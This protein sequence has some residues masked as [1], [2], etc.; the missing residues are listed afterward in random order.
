MLLATVR[1][2]V[3]SSAGTSLTASAFLN[4]YIHRSNILNNAQTDTLPTASAIITELNTFT[5]ATTGMTLDCFY[6][7]ASG[8]NINIVAGSGGSLSGTIQIS[9]G[10]LHRITMLL[11]ST[12][13]YVAMVAP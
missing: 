8:N 1:T 5:A 9:G 11:T 4:G 10:R 7:N 13:T 3:T 2:D 6:Y 12:T